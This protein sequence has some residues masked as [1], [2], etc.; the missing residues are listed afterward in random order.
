MKKAL[1]LL[2][3]ILLFVQSGI[4]ASANNVKS[5]VT[6]VIINDDGSALFTSTWTGSFTEGTENYI[7]I[8]TSDISVS[9]FSVSM[10]GVT[11]ESI[12]WDISASMEEKAYKCGINRT[13]EG[14]EL[15]WGISGYGENTYTLSYTVD[16]FIKH[17][18][19][20]DGTNF[21]FV[22]PGM[23]TFPTDA[24][25]NIRLKNKTL[26][27]NNCRIW[28][29]G[30]DGVVE[31]NKG[32]VTAETLSPLSGDNSLIIMLSMDHGI[33]SPA[34][35]TDKSFE[36][37][38]KEAF[39]GS[40]YKKSFP[41][42]AV[43]F[44]LLFAAALFFV[45]L[46][47]IKA[48]VRQTAINRFYKNAPYFRETPNNGDLPLSYSLAH[49]FGV[50]KDESLIIGASMLKMI[51]D[52][53][54]E[55]VTEESTSVFG[56]SKTSVSLKL[57][58]EPEDPLF[59]SLYG[60]LLPASG[61]D[62]ILQEKELKAYSNKHPSRLRNFINEAKSL[63]NRSIAQNRCFS[64][65]KGNLF[66]VGNLSESGKKELSEIMGL[67]KYL[68]DFSLISER[69]IKES[70]IWQDY[71]VYAA[72]LG[73]ADKVI[74]QMKKVYPEMTDEMES[75]TRNMTAVLYYNRIMYG[76]V[77][78]SEQ[79][80]RASGAGGHA[81]FGGGGGFSGGGHGGGSR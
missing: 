20:S 67:K 35:S 34:V 56:R 73:I 7:P 48:V 19:D 78:S 2:C 11:F 3:F 23:N 70:V 33:I 29:F 68:L 22:N 42:E 8:N 15:C 66:S 65:S 81:S 13:S 38:K 9:G 18:T 31:F 4:L 14:V 6:D 12:P 32:T 43:V 44:V 36:S 17:Y 53:S 27:E 51:N 61:A 39:K 59:K 49:G 41:W 52:G 45:I 77:I 50:S 62:G 72:L 24:V 21:M 57:V 74:A 80:A 54:L 63:G 37:V 5:I 75:Y 40:D 1:S 26:N 69:E 71:M 16:G 58:K 76:S 30:F 55:A 25:V 47:V 46:A 60:I 79:Q 28:A 64:S 10:N